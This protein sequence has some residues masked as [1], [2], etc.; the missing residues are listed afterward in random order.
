M[1]KIK[2]NYLKKSGIDSRSRS[3][4]GSHSGS[5]SYY[6]SWSGSGPLCFSLSGFLSWTKCWSGEYK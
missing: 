3:Y 2:N 6:N 1:K 4:S 5:Y